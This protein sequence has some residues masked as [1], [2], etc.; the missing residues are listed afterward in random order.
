MKEL[1]TIYN[2]NLEEIGIKT[3]D[4]VHKKGLRHKVVHCWIIE[5]LKEELLIYLQQRSYRK[6]DFAGLYDIS[7]AGHIDAGEEVENSMIRE[8]EEELGLHV[9]KNDLKYIG[10][11]FET[12]EM[13]NFSDDEICEMYILEV[14]KSTIFNLGE[15]VEN[16]VKLP[17]SQYKKWVNGELKILE[18][19]SIKD[20]KKVKIYDENI[21]PHIKEYNRQLF[22]ECKII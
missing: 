11:K 5:R 2:K 6:S 7:C 9:N 19:T 20:N 22:E 16:M 3:R 12:Y 17:F 13:K 18:A 21:C 1:L 10:R 4:E 14:D 8:L 15:E